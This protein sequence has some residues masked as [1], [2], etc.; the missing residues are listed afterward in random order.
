MI[1]TWA[2]GEGA[3][4]VTADEAVHE[5]G[6]RIADGHLESWL[7]SS[8]GRCLAVTTNTDR[9]MVMLLDGE[10]GS[11]EHVVAPGAEGV[12]DGFIL[13][14]GQNDEYPDTDTVTLGEALR[15]VQHVLA[16]GGPP[17]D[18]VWNADH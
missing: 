16:H 3:L 5:L 2:F 17:P 4:P 8:T 10:A 1:E 12:S 11:G 15:I 9:A 7:T 6:R 13:E 14:N 18:T